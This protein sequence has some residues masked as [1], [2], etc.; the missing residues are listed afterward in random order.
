M[1]YG[2]TNSDWVVFRDWL[3]TTGPKWLQKTYL[4]HGE[5]FAGFISNK[6]VIKH[7][8]RILMDRIVKKSKKEREYLEKEINNYLSKF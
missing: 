8:I 1:V 6:P 7:L 4:K 5:K 2:E 3:F